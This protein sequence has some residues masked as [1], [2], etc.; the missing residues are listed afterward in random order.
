[1]M[2]VSPETPMSGSLAVSIPPSAR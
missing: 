2:L 1:M